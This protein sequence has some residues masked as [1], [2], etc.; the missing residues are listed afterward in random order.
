MLKNA[1][2]KMMSNELLGKEENGKHIYKNVERNFRE[3]VELQIVL[4]DYNTKKDSRFKG[5]IV[6]DHAPYP[7]LPVSSFKFF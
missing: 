3:T 7:D 2:K 6:L 4:R 5:S 1:I